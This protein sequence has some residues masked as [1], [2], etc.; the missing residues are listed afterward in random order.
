MALG[1]GTQL[2]HLDTRSAELASRP[3]VPAFQGWRL[4]FRMKLQGQ[5]VASHRKGLIG[6]QPRGGQIR[7]TPG[8]NSSATAGH[9][10]ASAPAAMLDHP[11]SL[12][13]L[14]GYTAP[15]KATAIN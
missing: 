14:P 8:A 3:D 6:V 10:A 4:H 5:G 15:P 12:P 13:L 11:I 2:R 1:I 7:G 9:T